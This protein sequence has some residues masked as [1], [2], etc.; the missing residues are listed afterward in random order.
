LAKAAHKEKK[1]A[2]ARFGAKLRL[3]AQTEETVLY[4]AAIIMGDYLKLREMDPKARVIVATA[5]IQTTT[6]SDVKTAG[7]IA[8]LA[9]SF[10][11]ADVLAVVNACLGTFGNLLKVQVSFSVPRVELKVLETMLRTLVVDCE[12]LRYAMVISTKFRL[13]DSAVEGYLVI[14]LVVSSLDRLL[15]AVERLRQES[16]G[17]G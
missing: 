4:P 11:P 15:Q 5:D 7:A 14:V 10:S 9:K 3:H 13:R 8:Y 1:P 16:P 2:Q 12:G 17:A 6:R